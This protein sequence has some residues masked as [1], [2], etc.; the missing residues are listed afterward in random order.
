MYTVRENKNQTV[1][2]YKNGKLERTFS[3]T[4][5]LDKSVEIITKFNQLRTKDGRGIAELWSYKGFHYFAAY[6]EWL[7]WDFFVGI[8]QHKEALEFLRD[9][10]FQ[11]RNPKYYV[12]QRVKRINKLLHKRFSFLARFT[13]NIVCNLLRSRFIAEHPILINDVAEENFRFK[14][15]K[16]TLSKFTKFHRTEHPLPRTLKRFIKDVS[17]LPHGGLCLRYKP[18]DYDFDYESAEFL[19]DYISE[20]QFKQLIE[21]IDRRCQDA[22]A[23]TKMLEPLV[24]SSNIKAFIGYDQIELVAPLVAACKL[25]HINTYGYQHGPI[26]P[27]HLGWIAYGIDKDYCNLHVDTQISWGQYWI[28]LLLKTSNKFD[29]E[30]LKVGAHLNK[31]ISYTDFSTEPRQANNPISVLVPHEFLADNLAISDYI[32]EFL[33]LGWKVTLKLRP[34]AEGDIDVDMLSYKQNIRERVSIAYDISYG[35]AK[36]FD[37]VVCTQTVY[38]IEMMRFN[39]PIWYLET[40]TT[41]LKCIQED[42]IAH[43]ITLEMC[44]RFSD[45]SEV[46]PYLKPRYSLEDY[47]K[48][49]S[50]ISQDAFLK[51]FLNENNVEY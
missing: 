8:V 35:Q 48:V 42:G 9:K 3:P 11:I 17:I 38:A 32:N 24:A 5:D 12:T 6:Q 50:D 21:A 13:F 29:E 16:E 45:E 7:F 34:D 20:K 28:D 2:V 31:E 51:D 37:V 41:F 1:N 30:S 22:I 23:E 39:T 15:F 33:N 10:S 19:H 27:Y 36:E 18:A 43:A 26:S 47:K 49:F 25:N 46:N 44:R 14:R 4:M 40:G